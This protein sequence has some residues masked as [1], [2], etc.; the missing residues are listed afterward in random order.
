MYGCVEEH[1]GIPRHIGIFGN[2]SRIS[3]LRPSRARTDYGT[4]TVRFSSYVGRRR[5]HAV[6]SL[7]LDR[8]HWSELRVTTQ[9]Q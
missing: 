3:Q 6:A 5:R 1:I 2:F 8:G 4:R 9:Y 7:P